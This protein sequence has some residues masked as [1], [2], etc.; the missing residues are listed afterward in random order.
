MP[1][2]ACRRNHF[3]P[4]A[5]KSARDTLHSI[6]M[7]GAVVSPLCQPIT[8][9]VSLTRVDSSEQTTLMRFVPFSH[10]AMRRTS[11]LCVQSSM[12]HLLPNIDVEGDVAIA[13]RLTRNVRLLSDVP[14]EVGQTVYP[15]KHAIQQN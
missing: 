7:L 11:L 5:R 8:S 4:S 2:L 9:G 10:C 13:P 3:L 1:M 12:V 15:V 14:T 6:R